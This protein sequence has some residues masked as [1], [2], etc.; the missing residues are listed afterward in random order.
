MTSSADPGP[1]NLE[2]IRNLCEF[3][4]AELKQDGGNR[5]QV[6]QDRVQAYVM[7]V[8]KTDMMHLEQH[9]TCGTLFVQEPKCE[10]SCATITLQ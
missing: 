3:N 8:L 10:K 1:H 2:R 9:Q 7:H 4:W 6:I 5:A